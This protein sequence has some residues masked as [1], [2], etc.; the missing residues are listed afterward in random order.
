MTYGATSPALC[1]LEKLVHVEDP[2]LL[3]DL[4]MVTYEAPDDL[5]VKTIALDD[6]PPDWIA[7]ESL[8]QQK[9]HAFLRDGVAALLRVPS[10]V[11]PLRDSPDVNVLINHAHPAATQK[12]GFCEWSRFVS[13][14]AG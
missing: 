5:A 4:V 6:L 10:A 9:G 11:V 12:S 13:I 14:R 7:Q 1:V 3:P 2:A 8:T